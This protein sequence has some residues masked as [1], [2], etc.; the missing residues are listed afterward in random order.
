MN[1]RRL[2]NKVHSD[3][4]EYRKST[5]FSSGGLS[6]CK[7][8]TPSYNWRFFLTI[9]HY[10]CVIP[11]VPQ[12]SF[13]GPYGLSERHPKDRVIKKAK[14]SLLSLRTASGIFYNANKT[15]APIVDQVPPSRLI[16]V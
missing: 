13:V 10:C 1:F 8:R 6:P 4:K 15:P 11:Q 14:A 5:S 12:G 7:P 2:K 3:Q 9:K 16:P